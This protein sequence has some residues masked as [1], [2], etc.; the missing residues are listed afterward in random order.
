M[1]NIHFQDNEQ[2]HFGKL[3]PSDEYT[4]EI[5]FVNSPQTPHKVMNGKQL[6]DRNIIDSDTF[7]SGLGAEFYTPGSLVTICTVKRNGYHKEIEGTIMQPDTPIITSQTL[8]DF[9]GMPKMDKDHQNWLR[10]ELAKKD[11]LIDDLRQSHQKEINQLKR[12]IDEKNNSIIEKEATL[13]DRKVEI[14]TGAMMK[15]YLD[16]EIAALKLKIEK[17]EADKEITT[18]SLNDQMSSNATLE[19]FT[20]VAAPLVPVLADA[21]KGWITKMNQ[22]QIQQA[23]PI[24]DPQ[25]GQKINYNQGQLNPNMQNINPANYQINQTNGQNRIQEPLNNY[26]FDGVN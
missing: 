22:P 6:R 18:S 11:L 9:N 25:T 20:T 19:V 21:I 13:S 10:Q 24:F 16:K 12:T 14:S 4:S 17:L 5:K 2:Y 23:P 26:N 1:A 3:K 7:Y 8:N 15:E